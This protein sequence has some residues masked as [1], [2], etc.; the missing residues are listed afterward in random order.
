MSTA[1]ERPLILRADA[2]ARIGSGHLIR[3]FALAQTWRSIGGRAMLVSTGTANNLPRTIHSGDVELAFVPNAYPDTTDISAML[4]FIRE[5]RDAWVCCD[6]YNFDAG[7][8]QLLANEARGVVVIDD[9]ASQPSYRADIIVNQNIF[10]DRLEYNCDRNTKLLRGPRYALLRPE[11]LRWGNAPRKGHTRA[12]HLFVTMGGGDPDNQTLKVIRS[13]RRVQV[14]DVEVKVLVGRN[15][16]HLNQLRNETAN[17]RGIHLVLDPPDIPSLMAWADIAIS[18]GGSTCWELCFMGVPTILITLANN[19]T[20]VTTGLAESHAAIHLGHFHDVTEDLLARAVAEL[21]EDSGKREELSSNA[22]A[23][24]DGRG[25]LRVCHT[26]LGESED[27]DDCKTASSPQYSIQELSLRPVTMDDAALLFDWRN[28]AAVR[29]S[30]FEQGS[31]SFDTHLQWLKNKLAS[32]NTVIWMLESGGE[33]LGQIRYDRV[34][35]HAEVDIVIRSGLRGKGLGSKLLQL[36]ADKACRELGVN[37]LV[38]IVKE[39]NLASRSAFK[40]AG[41]QELGS[42]LHGSSTCF[43]YERTLD[44]LNGK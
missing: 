37:R 28:E 40:N 11:F 21:L 19:Q 34:E 18:A 10:S 24:V 42:L 29:V 4:Q 22:R 26:V 23:L 27:T 25:A 3:S 30:S 13:L 9:T 43:R 31:F 6:G 44:R 14:P 33:S 39:D 8:T 1:Y 12:K 20:G 16:S 41:F 2:N 36:S 38:G 15:N 32:P 17:A 7:Y 35:T 5:Y